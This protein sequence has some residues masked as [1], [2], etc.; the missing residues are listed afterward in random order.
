MRVVQLWTLCPLWKMCM[1]SGSFHN[2]EYP[3][4]GQCSIFRWDAMLVI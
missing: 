1:L 3:L 4:I 2:T